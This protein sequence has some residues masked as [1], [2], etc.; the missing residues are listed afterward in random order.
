MEIRNLERGHGRWPPWRRTVGKEGLQQPICY[1]QLPPEAEGWK[2]SPPIVVSVLACQHDG[3]LSQVKME[4]RCWYGE[5]F[6]RI[7]VGM[8]NAGCFAAFCMHSITFTSS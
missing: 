6:S 7:L 5:K 8:L 1:L 4:W 3:G 2:G